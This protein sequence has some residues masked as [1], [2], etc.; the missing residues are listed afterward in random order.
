[1][2]GTYLVA[3]TKYIEVRLDPS[4]LDAEFWD[5]FNSTITD[6]GGPDEEYLAEHIAWN[7]VQGDQYF[8]EGVGDLN[9]MNITVIEE[10]SDVQSEE[11]L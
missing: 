9:E 4:K 2:T 7:F 8:I 3:V 6:R 10:D 11:R 5:D 1:M